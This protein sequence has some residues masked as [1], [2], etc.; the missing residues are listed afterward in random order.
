MLL[1][2][3]AWGCAFWITWL[4]YFFSFIFMQLFSGY[5]LALSARRSRLTFA[6]SP[7]QDS[8]NALYTKCLQC[9]LR[10]SRLVGSARSVCPTRLSVEG[11]L[12]WIVGLNGGH[13]VFVF[14]KVLAKQELQMALLKQAVEVRSASFSSSSRHRWP[15][16]SH[17][18][19]WTSLD[20]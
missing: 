13:V 14:Q 1:S 11:L 17:K 3:V 8:V 10:D 7:P 6:I 15:P 16:I 9:L 18:Y 19:L 4:S 12:W 20:F 2:R 5:F